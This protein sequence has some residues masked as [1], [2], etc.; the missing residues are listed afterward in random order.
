MATYQAALD[1]RARLHS[2]GMRCTARLDP[3]SHTGTGS[4]A[5]DNRMILKDPRRRKHNEVYEHE[6][7]HLIHPTT[8][9]SVPADWGPR[10][11]KPDARPSGVLSTFADARGLGR[12]IP[13]SWTRI[14]APESGNTYRSDII[15]GE[16]VNGGRSDA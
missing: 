9:Q 8:T 12:A 4:A 3:A 13:S 15:V 11:I 2:G 1:E 14:R 5:G 10:G 6:C 7:F 16:Q